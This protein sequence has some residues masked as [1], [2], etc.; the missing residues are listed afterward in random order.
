MAAS[1]ASTSALVSTAR[2]KRKAPMRKKPKVRRDTKDDVQREISLVK[3]VD[4][5]ELRSDI[6][7]QVEAEGKT[8]FVGLVWR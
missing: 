4:I 8:M 6:V 1:K 5:E 7:L 2:N 3:D